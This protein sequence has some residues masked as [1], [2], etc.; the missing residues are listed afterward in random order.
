MLA[1]G[2][3]IEESSPL[4]SLAL[5]SRRLYAGFVR[6]LES[7]SGHRIDFQERGALDLAYSEAEQ[8]ELECKAN[9]KRRW[10]SFRSP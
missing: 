1:P 10:G 6:E 7:I 3:E 5:E 2:G 4:A 8:Q 9:V